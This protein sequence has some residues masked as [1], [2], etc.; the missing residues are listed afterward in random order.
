MSTEGQRFSKS[1]LIDS[2]RSAF[3]ASDRSVIEPI[4]W[5]ISKEVFKGAWRFPAPKVSSSNGNSIYYFKD[6]ETEIVVRKIDNN[7]K[8]SYNIKSSNKDKLIQQTIHLLKEPI[9]KYII[10]L[11]IRNFFGSFDPSQLLLRLSQEEKVSDETVNLLKALLETTSLSGSQGLPRGLPISSTLSEWRFQEVDR[12]IRNLDGVYYYGRFVDDMLIFAYENPR[13]IVKRIE[14][15]LDV[16]GFSLNYE[17]EKHTTISVVDKAEPGREVFSYLGYSFSVRC[18]SDDSDSLEVR[19]AENKI[20]KIKSRI[21]K[22]LLSF[23]GNSD[24]TL[25]KNR[26]RYLTGHYPVYRV[27]IKRE[28]LVGGMRCAYPH[29][30]HIEQL[31]DLDDFKAKALYSGKRSFARKAVGKLSSQQKREIAKISFQKAWEWNKRYMWSGSEI[32]RIAGVFK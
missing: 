5:K 22:A 24:Y 19:V 15:I 26:I 25:L 11:D 21:I 10:R 8:K 4:C 29:V 31:K 18:S 3:P 17:S 32:T 14:S 9:P 30:S 28:G 20:K 27:G 2:Y 13:S 1:R 12:K 16:N 7:I 23:G 6:V